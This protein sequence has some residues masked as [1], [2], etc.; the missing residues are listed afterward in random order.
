MFDVRRDKK[1]AVEEDLLA[2]S[3][4]HLVEL[5]ILLGVA[6]VPLKTGALSQ[7]IGE[8]GHSQMYMLDIYACQAR[9]GRGRSAPLCLYF[10]VRWTPIVPMASENAEV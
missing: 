3:L 2:L 9:E 6:G 5:P 7:V 8:A 4:R 10:A 1:R